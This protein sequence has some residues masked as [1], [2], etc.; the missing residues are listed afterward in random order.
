MVT[1]KCQ[2]PPASPTSDTLPPGIWSRVA[3]HGGL[4]FALPIHGGCPSRTATKDG[5]NVPSTNCRSPQH[6]LPRKE[7]KRLAHG[8]GR[9]R[10]A[11]PPHEAPKPKF[12]HLLIAC[13]RIPPP[14]GGRTK[15]I[16]SNRDR[17][18]LGTAL[19]QQQCH[20]ALAEI[21]ICGEHVVVLLFAAARQ[22]RPPDLP[23][24]FSIFGLGLSSSALDHRFRT[25]VVLRTFN[26]IAQLGRVLGCLTHGRRLLSA[27][28]ESHAE[29]LDEL[30]LSS[31]I[32][33]R[34][35]WVWSRTGRAQETSES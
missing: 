10:R 11:R 23:F 15:K 35:A 32:L 8:T 6:H 14:S 3:D 12:E 5:Q 25:C 31:W 29:L 21:G 2:L 9:V 19:A 1:Y 20:T 22:Y 18:L 4:L 34:S 7:K 13:C 17:D 28:P 27:R 26:T 24:L 33:C 16:G 30:Y